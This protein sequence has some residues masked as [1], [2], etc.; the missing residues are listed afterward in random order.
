MIS[1]IVLCQLRDGVTSADIDGMMRK[2]RAQLLKIPEVK[3]IRCGRR[4]ES[5]HEW[6][7]FVTLEFESMER[8]ASFR[9]NPLSTQYRELILGPHIIAFSE[10]N[11]ELD[12]GKD[13]RFS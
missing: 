8:L 7:F 4:I 3:S 6:G 1:H 9:A 11:Y 12:P 2:T 10:L 5:P 13:V